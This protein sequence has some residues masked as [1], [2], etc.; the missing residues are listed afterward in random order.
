MNLLI[1]IGTLMQRQAICQHGMAK[2]ERSRKNPCHAIIII[3]VLVGEI[4]PPICP[5]YNCQED[6]NFKILQLSP[7]KEARENSSIGDTYSGDMCLLG[8]FFSFTVTVV[9]MEHEESTP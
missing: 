2:Y 7:E 9:S 4:H 3:F 1:L 8:Y 6:G 5:G